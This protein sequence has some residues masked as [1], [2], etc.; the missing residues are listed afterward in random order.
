M[1]SGVSR[2]VE[3]VVAAALF[4]VAAAFLLRDA[5]TLSLTWDESLDIGVVRCVEQTRDP[6]ACLD[7][8]SQTRLPVYL[9]AAVAAVTPSEHAQYL[10]SAAFALTTLGLV[11]AF[12]RRRF[13][14]PTALLALALAGTAPSLLA[15]GRM[16]LSHANV[17]F[18]TFSVLTIVA[19]EH[20]DRT[21]T[22]RWFWT[23][24]VAFGLAAACSILG[25][26]NGLVVVG[27][28]IFGRRPRWW[29]P[30]AYAATALATFFATTVVYV[31]PENLR[32]LVEAT[33]TP[34]VYPYPAWNVLELGTNLAPSW[35]SPLLFAIRLGPW[36]AALFLAT[37]LVLWWGRDGRQ[38]QR[39]L[40]VVWAATALHLLGKAAVF[41]YDAPHQQA[42]WY[43][44][45]LVFVAATVVALV[46]RARR[47]IPV[48]V[49]VGALLVA[50]QLADALRF[51]PNYLF[52]GAQ[53]GQR[54]IGEFYGPA[55]L[56][57]QGRA[58][59]DAAIDRLA[60]AAPD[61]RF[62]VADNTSFEEQG[63]QFVPFS[64]RDPATTYRFALVD[65]LHA[66]HLEYP[67]R[68]PYNE[69]LASRY[70]VR[71]SLDYPLGEW[72]FRIYEL[73]GEE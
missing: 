63:E 73:R 70:R 35:Y 4:V 11:Y 1:P 24:A 20:H 69:L 71:Y 59:V 37:P 18:T 30:P 52:Y 50:V 57:K 51:F 60:A 38:A 33:L 39:S 3:V 32:A 47:L 72:A 10:L 67:D 42:P 41:R 55:V 12:A 8:I 17:I 61:A 40:L 43:P 23:S 22:R 5:G 13:G 21:G 53:Y 16:L 65:R 46:G 15:S 28:W 6:F 27:L 68:D 7:D 66:T 29:Q 14:V 54:A 31:R 62:L 19:A 44:I 34:D 25:L 64:K 9:H 48:A 49:A 45:V 2:R 56:H 58:E 36:W 26:A